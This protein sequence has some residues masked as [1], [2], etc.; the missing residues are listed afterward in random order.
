MQGV[1]PPGV[2]ENTWLKMGGNDYVEIND[3]SFY[4][5]GGQDFTIICKVVQYS[6]NLGSLGRIMPL[7]AKGVVA[8]G[9]LAWSVGATGGIFREI[10]FRLTNSGSTNAKIFGV[11]TSSFDI[12]TNVSRE[13]LFVFRRKNQD[14]SL[15]AALNTANYEVF[16]NGT[17]YSTSEVYTSG[18]ITA[19][20]F[21]NTG[22]A[23][24][25]GCSNGLTYYNKFLLYNRALSDAEISNLDLNIPI[26]NGL[27]QFFTFDS[28]TGYI[29]KDYSSVAN[30]GNL[31]DYTDS[32]VGIPDPNT[33]IMWA[34]AVIPF[35]Q[36]GN[37]EWTS[38][39]SLTTLK[40]RRRT[41]GMNYTIT[42]MRGVT[43]LATY[44]NFFSGT[45][46]ENVIAINMAKGDKFIIDPLG[47][48]YIN[49]LEI[50]Y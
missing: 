32:E 36:N 39:K 10:G 30:N 7:A 38:P 47:P 35:H 8:T 50:Y 33:N 14:G 40:F 24:L 19:D 16:I 13:L 20:P 21:T 17:K 2:I 41:N 3:S 11:P 34:T 12:N 48:D 6:S 46:I 31:M 5:F 42:H 27:R 49:A 37:K 15:I 43:T 45:S 28:K 1:T 23:T 25:R 9:N 22:V 44:P 29:V 18:T 4:N 26:E